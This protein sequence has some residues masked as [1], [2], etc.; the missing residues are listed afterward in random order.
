M[1]NFFEV[2]LQ[3]RGSNSNKEVISLVSLVSIGE[4]SELFGHMGFGKGN[5]LKMKTGENSVKSAQVNLNDISEDK[6]Y[7]TYDGFDTE[8]P[9]MKIKY[10]IA[11]DT[12]E[13]SEV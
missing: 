1:G 13:M 3:V 6:D 2:E 5:V 7:I 10:F 9:T 4:S 12:L 8:S 11:F